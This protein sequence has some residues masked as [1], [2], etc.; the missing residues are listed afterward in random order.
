MPIDNGPLMDAERKRM[1]S[2]ADSLTDSLSPYKR[3]RRGNKRKLMSGV[4]QPAAPPAPR[5]FK[6]KQLID[7][8]TRERTIRRYNTLK[9]AGVDLSGISQRDL[10][11]GA[12]AR[13]IKA[14]KRRRR[15]ARVTYSAGPS[16]PNKP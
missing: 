8:G 13:K 9:A 11:T 10:D 1:A 6:N 3:R 15:D 16:T 7:S 14:I 4:R 5:R 2:K 12:G